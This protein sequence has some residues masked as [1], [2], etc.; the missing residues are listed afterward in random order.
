MNRNKVTVIVESYI[1]DIS[2]IVEVGQ[3]RVIVEVG[4]VRVIVEVGQV[5]VTVG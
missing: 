4:Q 1:M 5:R 3:V 2:G